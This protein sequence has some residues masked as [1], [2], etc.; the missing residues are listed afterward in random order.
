MTHHPISELQ[1]CS[2]NPRSR[3][4]P[5][6]QAEEVV[7]EIKMGKNGVWAQIAKT[8]PIIVNQPMEEWVDWN[9]KST[10]EVIFKN[11]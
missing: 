5:V 1:V 3:S 7:E 2:Y 11:Y 9:T 6:L 4:P 10:V 8:N